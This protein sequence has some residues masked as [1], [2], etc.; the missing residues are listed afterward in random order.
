MRPL[1][2]VQAIAIGDDLNGSANNSIAWA[3]A[4]VNETGAIA[5]GSQALAS[6]L[7][8]IAI[9]CNGIFI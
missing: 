3:F 6:D 1:L 9:A 2:W 7:G 5:F 8:V 4:K